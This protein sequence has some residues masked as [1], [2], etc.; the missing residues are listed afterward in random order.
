MGKIAIIDCDSIAYI[1]FHP[2]KV[3]DA[4][5]NPLRENNKFVYQDKSER[6]IEASL[7]SLMDNILSSGGFTDYIGFVKG[8][9]TIIN[10]LSINPLYKSNRNAKQPKF[11]EFTKQSMI[12]RWKAV[13][14]NG[15]EVDD[16]VNITRLNIKDSFITAIDKDLLSLEGTH[17]NWKKNEWVT[18][19]T[20]E[21]D[22]AFWSDMICG[23][24]G[25]GLIGLKGKGEKYVEQLFKPNVL[26]PD[27]ELWVPNYV[28]VLQAYYDYYKDFE[29]A[30]DEYTKMYKCLKILD[31]SEGFVIPEPINYVGKM[32]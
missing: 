29:I 18:V 13:E 28:K 16:A 23:Q 4:N 32:S 10:R 31:K 22:T 11:W 30:L 26:A 6:Q 3:L 19:N 5:G 24:P 17:Y 12:Q 27:L 2:N 20:G 7:D 21:A 1:A 15:L 25:D 9:N 14:V 8:K